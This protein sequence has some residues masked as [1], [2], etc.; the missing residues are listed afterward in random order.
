MSRNHEIFLTLVLRISLF[1]FPFVV[2][3]LVLTRV[4]SFGL[5]TGASAFLSAALGVFLDHKLLRDRPLSEPLAVLEIEQ[6]SLPTMEQSSL[7]GPDPEPA[8]PLP[9]PISTPAPEP[10]ALS[11]ELLEAHRA[12]VR[13]LE[14]G[15]QL[16]RQQGEQ[17]EAQKRQLQLQLQECERRLQPDPEA[18]FPVPG[19]VLQ[20]GYHGAVEDFKRRLLTQSI[21]LTKGNRAEAA[22]ELGLQRTYLYRLVKQFQVRA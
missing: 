4:L 19:E 20:L 6:G 3:E 18:L 9:E 11:A 13:G 14:D 12:E 16:A 15:L 10:P 5:A 1:A 2:I 8:P 17:L 22:R 7:P 21:S